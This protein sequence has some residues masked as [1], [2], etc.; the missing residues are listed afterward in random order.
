MARIRCPNEPDPLGGDLVGCGKTFDGALVA[1][2]FEGAG[3][4]AVL[5]AGL[6]LESVEFSVNSWRG[7]DFEPALRAAIAI[8][9]EG[10]DAEW[11][12]Q[13]QKRG[14][15]ARYI[16]PALRLVAGGRR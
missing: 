16:R 15:A 14:V 9:E 2:V 1:A 5:D 12:A 6:A 3:R 10:R 11:R 7:D 13:Q 8:Y 4:V